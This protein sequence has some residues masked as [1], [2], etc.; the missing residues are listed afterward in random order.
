LRLHAI[1]RFGEWQGGLLLSDLETGLLL[2]WAIQ[3]AI[4]ATEKLL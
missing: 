3:N 4:S 1:H 2:A